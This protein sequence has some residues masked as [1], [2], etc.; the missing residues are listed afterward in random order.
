MHLAPGLGFLSSSRDFV[1]QN[2]RALE[3]VAVEIFAFLWKRKAPPRCAEAV[4]LCTAI[5]DRGRVE[6]G[7]GPTERWPAPSREF[8]GE[9]KKRDPRQGCHPKPKRLPSCVV[10]ASAEEKPGGL[11]L[12]LSLM[13]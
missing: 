11:F 12:T 7:W 9:G 1:S 5:P 8:H 3:Q 13:R 10:L 4:G 2:L 6:L